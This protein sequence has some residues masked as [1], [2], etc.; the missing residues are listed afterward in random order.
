MTAR[1]NPTLNAYRAGLRRGLVSSRIMLTTP[2]DVLGTVLP[3]AV[4]VG[5]LIFLRRVEVEGS[6]V[7]LATMSL[8]GL[9]AMGVLFSAVMGI[10]GVL[11]MD[12]TNG[13]LLRSKS[14]PGGT[15]G[16]LVGEI[17][18]NAI[19][20]VVSTL[21]LLVVG[22]I[23][24]DG[25]EF[26][27]P[28]R[29]LLFT[30]VLLVGLVATLALGAVVGAL[31]DSPKNMGLVMLPVMGLISI[32]GIFYPLIAL[33][34]WLQ[35]IAQVFP[36]YW[37]GLGMRASLLPESMAGVEVGETWRIEWVFVV[38]IVWAVASMVMAPK[39]LSRMA[40]RESGSVVAARRKELQQQ[41]G[42]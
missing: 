14:V 23:L 26:D 28:G 22:L 37:F 30:A 7:S 31:I 34:V 42:V 8:P 21:V 25:L 27:S 3:L 39:L 9:L 16:Y 36:L 19:V 32:S 29:W 10:A 24:F 1:I 41:W 35:W 11:V 5:V 18:A 6:A 33:P 17:V 38:L 40:R 15:T 13:T 4:F 20:T 2:A 12:R